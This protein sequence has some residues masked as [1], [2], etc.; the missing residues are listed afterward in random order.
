MHGATSVGVYD[1]TVA[2][3]QPADYSVTIND[4]AVYATPRLCFTL[5]APP[6]TSKMQI[7]NDGSFARAPW[8]TFTTTK[9]WTLV[10]TETPSYARCVRAVSGWQGKHLKPLHG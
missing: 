4:G 2:T 3:V 6:N 1:Y 10:G 9:P 7:S 8:E 5:T